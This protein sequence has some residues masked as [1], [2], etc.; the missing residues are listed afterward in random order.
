MMTE[1]RDTMHGAALIAGD[2]DTDK[3]RQYPAGRQCANC[4]RPLSRYNGERRCGPCQRAH[5]RAKVL[6]I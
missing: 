2:P 4:E 1:L 3:V 6:G 5:H